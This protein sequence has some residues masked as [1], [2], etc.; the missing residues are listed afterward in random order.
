VLRAIAAHARQAPRGTVVV[1]PSLPR[2]VFLRLIA[3][4]DV[5]VGNSSAGI[6][7]APFLGTPVVNVGTRQ[8]GREPGGPGIIHV[9]ERRTPAATASAI[10]AAIR[11]ALR[12]PQRRS[13]EAR[14]RHAAGRSVYGDGRSGVRIAQR[15]ALVPLTAA[16][17][18]K[19]IT[20]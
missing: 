4:A 15:L 20:Y 14:A 3:R 11:R 16:L 17:L 6:I 19:Q 10:A 1:A 2:E 9:A 8:A 18:H 5:L 13:A 7:E 12:M